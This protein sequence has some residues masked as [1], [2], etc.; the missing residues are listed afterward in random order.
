VIRGFGHAD[1]G[2]RYRCST[3]HHI[4]RLGR[5]INSYITGLILYWL[6]SADAKAFVAHPESATELYAQAAAIRKRLN[7]L[8]VA[9]TEGDIDRAQ[10]KA[11]TVRINAKLGAVNDKIDSGLKPDDDP[12]GGV[13]HPRGLRDGAEAPTAPAC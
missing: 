5:N 13:I 12:P 8:S 7:G 10:L 3:N 1:G 2:A 11:A 9:F 6:R 4:A